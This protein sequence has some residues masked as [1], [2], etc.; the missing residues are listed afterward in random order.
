M[1]AQISLFDDSAF[2][3][4]PGPLPGSDATRKEWR[5][6][7]SHLQFEYRRSRSV[8]GSRGGWGPLLITPDTNIL[9]D[10]VDAFDSVESHFGLAGPVPPGDREDPVDALRELFALWF[11]RDVRWVI[12]D[13]YLVDSRK[14]LSTTRQ[15][16]RERVLDALRLDL[17]DRG[18]LER[19]GVDRDLAE[20]NCERLRDWIAEDAQAREAAK[21]LAVRAEHMLPGCDG[22]LVA[23]ALRLGS[24]VFLTE[25]CGILAHARSLFGWGLSILRPSELLRSLED[26]GE[27][28][29][30]FSGA[31]MDLVP[32]LLP[33]SRFYAIAPP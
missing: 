8:F 24:H 27:L 7:L 16:D 22:R 10:L 14:P 32:D 28:D 31:G 23:D 12:S 1:G 18:G 20:E 6:P 17:Y 2:A 26:T 9:I 11:C 33:L 3:V 13:L 5:G 4:P 19:A 25:D 15:A 21:P 30:A 29:D